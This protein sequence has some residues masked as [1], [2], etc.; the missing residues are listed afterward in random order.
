M[1]KH[2]KSNLV[3]F[4][5]LMAMQIYHV[6]DKTML[7]ALAT[8]EESG[9]YYNAD[10]LINIPLTIINGVGTVLLPRITNLISH[11]KRDQAN[12][13]FC[14]SIEGV[15]LA[16]TAMAFGVAAI[17][18]EFVPLFFG[19]GFVGSILITIVLSPVLVVKGISNTIRTEFLIP[20]HLER[21][22]IAS[23]IAGAITNLIANSILIPKFGG[24][25]A[26][27]GTLIAEVVACFWQITSIWKLVNLRT[28]LM[29]SVLYIVFGCFMYI[30]V[31]YVAGIIRV[32]AV[33]AIAIEIAVGMVFY[34]TASLLYL[35]ATKN[36][37]LS[38][39]IRR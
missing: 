10:K 16:S 18:N 8:Y 22:F 36:K 7:G 14:T 13:L 17:S 33:F 25:G 15:V 1:T 4:V 30:V 11:N 29:H 3:L 28:A 24:Y 38:S 32:R 35:K 5:P 12:Q 19:P 23:V 39:L 34:G 31:R 9:Y 20:Y 6:M 27:I 21:K 37:L 2:I 26:A